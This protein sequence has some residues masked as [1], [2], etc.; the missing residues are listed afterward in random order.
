M[1]HQVLGATEQPPLDSSLPSTDTALPSG[2]PWSGPRERPAS[3]AVQEL[4]GAGLEAPAQ[5]REDT[6]QVQES[7]CLLPAAFLRVL[8]TV[9]ALW[10]PSDI[11]GS[12][13]STG[14]QQ[15]RWGQP[16]LTFFPYRVSRETEL[17]S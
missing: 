16:W 12:P 7:R 1:S 9:T 6:G 3:T 4:L 10:P 13:L 11:H 15:Q 14:Q 2:E 17:E 5:E 8:C